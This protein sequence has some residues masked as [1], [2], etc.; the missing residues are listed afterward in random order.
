M[1]TAHNMTCSM[2]PLS[3]NK[4]IDLFHFSLVTGELVGSLCSVSAQ[5]KGD[6]HDTLAGL[7]GRVKSLPQDKDVLLQ[8]MSKDSLLA[9]DKVLCKLPEHAEPDN[10]AQGAYNL[11]D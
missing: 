8:W 11:K 1:Q 5:A 10:D 7:E 3:T 9:L 2:I 6:G 4:G